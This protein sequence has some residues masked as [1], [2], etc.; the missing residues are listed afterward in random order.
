MAED[1]LKIGLV[2]HDAGAVDCGAVTH[3]DMAEERLSDTVT[4][5]QMVEAQ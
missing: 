1:R 3:A 4:Q 2:A 5:N